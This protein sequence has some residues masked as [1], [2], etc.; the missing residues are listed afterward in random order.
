MVGRIEECMPGTLFRVK[1]DNGHEVL[2]TLG[3]RLRLNRIRLLPGD[4]VRIEVSPYD[5]SRGRVVF[6]L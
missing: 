4:N 6:R 1:C 3:G 5:L 2:A